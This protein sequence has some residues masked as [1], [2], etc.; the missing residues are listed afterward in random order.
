MNFKETLDKYIDIIDENRNKIV[1]GSLVIL[2]VIALII[3]LVLSSDE[4]SVKKE[5]NVLLKNIEQREYSIALE[6]Y[7]NYKN[8][9]SESKMRRLN[10]S[11][12][13]KINQLLTE[14][15]DK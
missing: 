10:K 12:S 13:G 8:Q 3:I 9:F 1:T 11:L 7:N 4:L 5:A 2:G 6:H 15:G 14:S